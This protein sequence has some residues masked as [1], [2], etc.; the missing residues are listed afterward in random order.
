MNGI[1]SGRRCGAPL[2]FLAL[3]AL[4]LAPAGCTP[5]G[6]AVGGA[7]AAGVAASEERGLQGALNDTE[8]RLQIN[9][10]WLQESEA[11]FREVNLQVQE[12]RVLLSGNVP[13]PETRVT[14]VRLAWQADGVREV[15]NEIEVADTSSLTDLARDTWIA[16]KLK[17]RLLL[18]RDVFSINYSIEV[19]NGT[20]YLMG[21]AQN[22]A[23]LD[24]VI[25]HAKDVAY[26]RRVVS[27]VRLKDAPRES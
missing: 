23:E 21:I 18:D 13:D 19:V 6:M 14:A 2:L 1:S 10:L 24:R 12:G 27:Y 5:T 22:K 26:V 16:T 25:G 4:G 3:A 8:I 20:V 15:I 17:T 7:A 9:H 11:L